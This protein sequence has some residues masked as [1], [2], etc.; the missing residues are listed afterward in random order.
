MSN[1][2]LGAISTARGHDPLKPHLERLSKRTI[3]G[4]FT[5]EKSIASR[6]LGG[7]VTDLWSPSV[8]A[9][10]VTDGPQRHNATYL[11]DGMEYAPESSIGLPIR[12]SERLQLL[13]ELVIA[14]FELNEVIRV[15]LALMDSSQLDEMREVKFDEF[16]DVLI[17][18]MRKFAPPD[19]LYR[20]TRPSAK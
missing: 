10:R 4:L 11:I 5:V 19:T 7:F 9:I 8:T 14:I 13:S 20:I 6:T 1:D 3:L 15:D 16:P 2:I 17:A 18:D 12:S